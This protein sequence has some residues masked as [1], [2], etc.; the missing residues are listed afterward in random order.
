MPRKRRKIDAAALLGLRHVPINVARR[1]LEA[2]PDLG[3]EYDP[4]HLRY[5]L[6][7]ARKEI[8][9]D[10]LCCVELPQ[11]S[12][13]AYKWYIGRPQRVLQL[14][15]RHSDALKEFFKACQVLPMSH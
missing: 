4:W 1:V 11:D 12:G 8:M 15:A 5:D 2:L 14:F 7:I 10:V 3:F 6:E 13:G 9:D